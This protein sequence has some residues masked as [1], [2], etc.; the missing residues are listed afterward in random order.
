MQYYVA[1]AGALTDKMGSKGSEGELVWAGA[2]Y[3][4]F[5]AVAATPESL[6]VNF[7]NIYGKYFNLNINVLSRVILLLRI[8]RFHSFPGESVYSHTMLTRA[9]IM[10]YTVEEEEVTASTWLL[11]TLGVENASQAAVKLS[12]ITIL[13]LILS[14]V[15]VLVLD[16][17]FVARMKSAADTHVGADIMLTDIQQSQIHQEQEA[18]A[19]VIDSELGIEVAHAHAD[20]DSN[21]TTR[22][23]LTSALFRDKPYQSVNS[24]QLIDLSADDQDV[25]TDIVQSAENLF[26]SPLQTRSIT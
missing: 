20:V 5:A 3:S 4:A 23:Y 13:C 11:E 17:H 8:L 16:A 24:C 14:V 12:G 2:G 21:G 10:P 9:T 25:D 1:G 6:T 22:G 26:G 15:A 19:E 18:D 7:V